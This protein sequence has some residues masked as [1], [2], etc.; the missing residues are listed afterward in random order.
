[1]ECLIDA[2]RTP[3]PDQAAFR[4]DFPRWLTQQSVWN[5]KIAERLA[6]GLTTGEVA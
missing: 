6:L 5:R 3:V 4:I 2:R 1:M